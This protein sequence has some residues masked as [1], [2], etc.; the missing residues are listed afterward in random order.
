MAESKSKADSELSLRL[1]RQDSLESIST[2]CDRLTTHITDHNIRNDIENGDPQH[3]IDI[4]GFASFSGWRKWIWPI[5]NHELS[6]VIPLNLMMFC[7]LFSY[8]TF[9]DLKDS[10]IL[11]EPIQTALTLQWCQIIV[12][13]PLSFVGLLVIFR[14][15]SAVPRTMVF[16]SIVIFFMCYFIVHVTLLHP[17][18]DVLHVHLLPLLRNIEESLDQNMKTQNRLIMPIIGVIIY[19][20]NTLFYSMAELWATISIQ[21]LLSFFLFVS[22]MCAF[23]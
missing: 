19:P 14:L 18:R 15:A 4:D 13:L 22:S 2:V 5:H 3:H 12:V 16:I 11:C 21:I 6:R 9:E 20:I 1:I 8:T 17:N 10:L 23:V 7:G